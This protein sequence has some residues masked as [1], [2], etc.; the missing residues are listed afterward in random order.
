MSLHNK[1]Q[2]MLLEIESRVKVSEDD[3]VI[4]NVCK[5]EQ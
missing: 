4:V 3:F 1:S 5:A 2:F